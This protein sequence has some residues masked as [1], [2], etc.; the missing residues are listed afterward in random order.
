MI[1]NQWTRTW[2]CGG[3]AL[4]PGAQLHT[5]RAVNPI[6][7]LSTRDPWLSAILQAGKRIENRTWPTAKLL[8][9]RAMR[10]R[11]K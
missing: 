5:I 6:R 9:G 10:K 2:P 1:R 8:Y 3:K 11:A 4:A 7:A